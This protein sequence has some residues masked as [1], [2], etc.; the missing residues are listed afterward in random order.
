MP[1]SV[2]DFYTGYEGEPEIRFSLASDGLQ[3]QT[4][5]LWVGYFDAIMNKVE[6]EPSGWTALALPYHLNA[7]WYESSPWRI[8][9]LD[10][11]VR[12]WASIDTGSLPADCAAAHAAVLELLLSAKARGEEVTISYD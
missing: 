10:A 6:T 3:M 5:R 7:G 12:Q 1:K 2:I 11:V 8:T 9:D 4:V